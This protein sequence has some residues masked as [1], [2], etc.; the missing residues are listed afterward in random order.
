MVAARIASELILEVRYK[1]CMM[2]VP[3]DRP[4]MLLG[5]N[6]S[7]ILSTTVPSATLKKKHQAICYHRIRECIAAKVLQFVHI[8]TKTKA[9]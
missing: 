2:G 1:L 9:T 8:N 3:I 4:V 5:D 6:F 7:V